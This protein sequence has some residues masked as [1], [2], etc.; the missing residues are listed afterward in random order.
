MAESRCPD[1]Y[2]MC[3]FTG[4]PGLPADRGGPK[5]AC[6]YSWSLP[7]CSTCST[8]PIQATV[9][10]HPSEQSDFAIASDQVLKVLS[11]Q[12]SN[13]TPPVKNNP[14]ME[15]TNETSPAVET[16]LD[17]SRFIRACLRR[18]VDRTPV[19]FL[20]QAGRYM[21]EYREVRKHH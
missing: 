20:R 9:R 8:R 13:P 17:G 12:T 19:W 2:S 15:K 4:P 7:P 16:I 1:I 6:S 21:Q 10:T 18:P 14:S 5:Q 3:S 11:T